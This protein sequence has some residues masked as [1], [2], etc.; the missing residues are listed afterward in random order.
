MTWPAGRSSADPYAN[1][2]DAQVKARTEQ[3]PSWY[4]WR[5]CLSVVQA[6][7]RS[8]GPGM[9]TRSPTCL[10]PIFRVSSGGSGGAMP[11][12]FLEAV[13]SDQD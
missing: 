6:Y 5:T 4:D 7:G 1:L 8:V 2:G 10:M 12:W 13:E 11:Q 9:T 3:D